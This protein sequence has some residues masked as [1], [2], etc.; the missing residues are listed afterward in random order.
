M[1]SLSKWHIIVIYAVLISTITV[2][3]NAATQ[4]PIQPTVKPVESTATQQIAKA[5]N[6]PKPTDIPPTDTPKPT[7]IPPT[8]TPKPT[9][10]P[11][12]PTSSPTPSKPDLEILSHQSYVDNGWYHIVGEVQNNTNTPMEYVKIAATLYNDDKKVVGTDYTYTIL[13]VIPPGGKSPFETG[14]DKWEGTTNYK[15]QS[16]GSEGELSRQDIVIVSHESYQDGDWLHVR[17]EVKNTGT[18]QAE[19][20][21]LIV[22]LYNTDGKVVG[23]DYTYTSL[24]IVQPGE[25]SPFETGTDHWPDFD[26]YEIQVQGN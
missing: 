4:A 16:E 3:C 24:D 13:E 15:L 21:K 20:V 22:T 19:Y 11:A 5:T 12:Q 10:T 17:G 2:A 8:N 25:T 18:T 7:D 26:H 14:T 9:K 23:T 1:Y 6:T